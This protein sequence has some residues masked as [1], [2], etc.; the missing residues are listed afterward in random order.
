MPFSV[1]EPRTPLFV[2]NRLLRSRGVQA[3]DNIARLEVVPEVTPGHTLAHSEEEHYAPARMS[4]PLV[5]YGRH[6]KRD[7]EACYRPKH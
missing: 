1:A 7:G 3:R 2:L 4:L 5:R 6:H